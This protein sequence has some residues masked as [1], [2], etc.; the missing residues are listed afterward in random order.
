MS[1]E[2]WLWL[3]GGAIVGYIIGAL[4]LMQESIQQTMTV[5]DS[6]EIPKERR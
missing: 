2:P 5:G 1:L 4:E 3:W 6:P